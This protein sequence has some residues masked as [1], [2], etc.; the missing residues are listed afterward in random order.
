MRA[1]ILT[2]ADVI[3]RIVAGVC[4]VIV[5]G[6]AIVLTVVMTANV[7]A[8]YVLVTGGFSFAQELPTLIFPWF[9]GAGVVLSALSG[10]HMAVE[11]IYGKMSD[12]GSQILFV[13][14]SIGVA[15]SFL[16][17]LHQALSVAAIAGAERSPILRL[18]NSIGYY[19]VAVMSLLVAVACLTQAVRVALKGWAARQP[20]NTEELPI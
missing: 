11:W 19:S 16:V 9:I 5:L 13:T 7:V 14:A 8:R 18:P 2:A 10:T 17:L 1:A 6:T 15:V 4:R 20:A 12:R 3:D